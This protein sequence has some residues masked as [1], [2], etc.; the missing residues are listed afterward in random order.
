[1]AS[2][3]RTAWLASFL[4]L[5]WLPAC[6]TT[7]TAPA[8]ES[9]QV[10]TD[11]RPKHSRRQQRNARRGS[12]GKFDFYVLS[13]SW[14]PGF[15]ATPA[16]RH[17]DLQCGPGRQYAFVLHGLWPQYEG[18]GWPQ[19][20]STDALDRAT[21][22]RML[23]I[24]P[25]P[26]L[27]EHE[28]R[29]H[30][31]CSGLSSGD[32][33]E[34]AEEAFRGLAIP[35]DYRSPTRQIM[36]NPAKMQRDFAAANPGFGPEGIVVVCSSNGRFLQEVRACL[37]KDLEGRRCNAEVLRSACDSREIIMRPVR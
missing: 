10:D 1:M 18:R 33:F 13:L 22:E 19:N 9:R 24:M 4:V 11:E 25:S 36:V 27:V 23:P 6:R 34:E 31:T 29:K 28:W 21:V 37:S 26:K 16:G 15:C 30:G 8:R 35:P 12:A 20:C 2:V 7:T 3:Y 17:D 32:Y 14:S 5:L